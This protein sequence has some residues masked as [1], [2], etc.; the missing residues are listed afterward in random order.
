MTKDITLDEKLM[1]KNKIPVLVLDKDWKF[2]FEENMT[3]TMKK[4]A[5]DLE[6][7]VAEEKQGRR[8]MLIYKKQKKTLMEK[9][10]QFS[11]DVNRNEKKESL[12]KLEQAKNQLLEINDQMDELQYKLETLPKEI[13]KLNLTLLK[14]TINLAY[15]DIE[16]DTTK[17][18]VLTETIG[19]L[20]QQLA[21]SWDEK[22]TLE[23]KVQRM[24]SY[25]HN[26]LGHEETNKLDK[27]FL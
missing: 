17:I 18:D 6:K 16:E 15:R 10:L 22:I 2:L 9:I 8:Q 13:E 5:K 26:T 21:E 14:E 23:E 19:K 7:M 12:E 11:D 24:Y 4:A 1:K 25:L 3:K 20:R 27:K